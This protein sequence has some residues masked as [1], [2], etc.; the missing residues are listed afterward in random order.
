[1]KARNGPKNYIKKKLK[2]YYFKCF[3]FQY[4]R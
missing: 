3:Y 1:M 2:D 4:D